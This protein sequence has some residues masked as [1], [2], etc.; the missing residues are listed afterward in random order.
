MWCHYLKTLILETSQTPTGANV[1][2]LFHGCML[3]LFLIGWSIFRY[4]AFPSFGQ[5]YKLI[6]DVITPPAAYFSMIL[7]ELC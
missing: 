2:K 3:G 5:Y 1:I 6:T 7:T 4:Q